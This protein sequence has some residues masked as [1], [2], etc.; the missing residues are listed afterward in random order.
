MG[1]TGEY[2]LYKQYQQPAFGTLAGKSGVKG[3]ASAGYHQASMQG[4]PNTTPQVVGFGIPSTDD[5]DKATKALESGILSVSNPFEVS[6]VQKAE[7]A[8]VPTGTGEL[9]P[10]LEGRD[11]EIEGCR[12]KEYYA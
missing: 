9:S 10:V 7:S 6:G 4:V 8:Y 3:A 11:D 12:W 5:M 1:I 2:S